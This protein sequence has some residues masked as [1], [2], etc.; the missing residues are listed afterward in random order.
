MLSVKLL[1]KNIWEAY[2]TYTLKLERVDSLPYCDAAAVARRDYDGRCR[3][4]G[5]YA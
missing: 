1:D 3:R 5:S 2:S 4:E